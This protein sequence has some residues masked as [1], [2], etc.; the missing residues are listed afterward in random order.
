MDHSRVPVL[1]ALQEFRR[2][3]DVVFGPP[4]HGQG[5][6]ADRR[7]V[8]VVGMGVFASDVLMLNGLDDRRQSQGVLSQ[9]QELMADAVGAEQAFFSTCGSS[10]SVKSAMISVAG[11]GEK[12]LVSRN[13]HKSVIA[14]LIISGI[15]PVWVHPHFDEDL[16]L[17]HPPEPEDVR[18]ALEANPDA[19][20][21]LL[22]S[23]T[24]WGTCADIAG[25]AKVC[26]EYDVPLI[27]DEAWGAHLPFHDDLPTWGMSADADLVVTS[28][29]KMGGAIEQSSTFHLQGGRI[30]P[31]VLQ[32]RED[33]LG[34][35]SSSSL[36]Y[37]T[38]DGWRRQMV[39]QG[40]ELLDGAMA[41]A[42]RIRAAVDALDGLQLMGQ[43]VVRPQ[44]AAELDPLAI[45]IDV[46]PLGITG[47]QAGDWLRACCQVDVGSTDACRMGA[48]ITHAHGDQDEQ[49]LVEALSRLV[50][51]APTMERPPRVALPPGPSFE[52]E[53]VML[54]RDAF[55]GPAEQVP[56]DD[57]VGRVA[58]EMVSPYPPGVP[59]LAPG[60]LVNTEV[61]EYLRTGVAAG[62]LIPDAA[63]PEM[64]SLR[65][66]AR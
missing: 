15:D 51:E 54:P 13:A 55:F 62:M 65:V 60:E 39:E 48:R 27:V 50:R 45:T 19:K 7:V 66:V 30:D 9:A 26:H 4:A 35:T 64:T 42:G 49:R 61:V 59:V 12:L 38:L 31:E 2:R 1:E 8:D 43:E 46:R 16:H 44:G 17:A 37:A 22:I 57:A 18:A 25:V 6:G 29:H 28:V 36:V 5:R 20:G 32:A 21:M 33:L 63:D 3:G 52:V 34:T 10:L 58:A 23:P 53:T 24:D 41:R 56:I 47:Y 11:P 14:A 40:H